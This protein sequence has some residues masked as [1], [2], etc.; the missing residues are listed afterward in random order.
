MVSPGVE[1]MLGWATV[2]MILN[3]SMFIS[4]LTSYVI[5]NACPCHLASTE[6]GEEASVLDNFGFL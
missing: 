4:T 2:I 6:E 1:F 5:S 3:P